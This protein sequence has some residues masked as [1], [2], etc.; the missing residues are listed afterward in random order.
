MAQAGKPEKWHQEV[1][2]KAKDIT[3]LAR[4]SVDET[5]STYKCGKQR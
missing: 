1:G 3:I 2:R 4:I 5:I